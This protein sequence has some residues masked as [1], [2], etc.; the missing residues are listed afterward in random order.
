MTV[1]PSHLHHAEKAQG[2]SAEGR[3]DSWGDVHLRLLDHLAPPSVLVDAGHDILHLSPAAGRFL[4]FSGGEPSRNLLH[5]VH[6]ALRVELRAALD[7]AARHNE[8]SAV[9]RV[10]ADLGNGSMAI[11]MRVLPA[12]DIAAGLMLVIFQ[13]E[14]SD[15][16]HDGDEAAQVHVLDPVARQL[17][18]E[19]ERLKAQLR[20]T[21]EQHE[22]STEQLKASNEELQAMNEE[23]RSAAGELET[24][25]RD[26]QSISEKLTTV[27]H[28]L[29]SKVDE[30]GHANSDMHNLMDAT[31]I[32]TVFLDRQ[33]RI[34]RYTPSAVSLFHLIATDVGRPL[35]D[36]TSPLRYPTLGAD[37]K[38]ALETLTTVERE[39]GERGGHWYLARIRPYRTIDDRIAGVVLTFV[40]ITDRKR[41]QE[42]LLNADARFRAIVNQATV[43]V[44]QLDL[45]GRLTFANE[46]MCQLLGYAESELMGADVATLVHPDDLPLH[47][48]RMSRLLHQHEPFEIEK[49]LLRRDG[50]ELWVHNS[51]TCLPDAH[52]HV[53]AT[54]AVCVDI[55]ERKR[56]ES[57]LRN[58][59]EH[60]RM[61]V[62]NA[63]EYAIFTTDLD[64]RI[65]GW[66]TG[67]QRILGYTGQEAIGRS[68]DMI[69]TPEDQAEGAPSAEAG[70]ALAEGRA[71]DD[72]WHVRKD[73]SRLWAS[74]VMMAMHDASGQ[75]AGFVKILRDQTDVRR[76]Q[77]ALEQAL[78]DNEN[79]RTALEAANVAKDQ[80]LAVLSHELRTP[81]TPAVM[82]LQLLS[83]RKD[84]PED[85]HQ[86]LELIRRNIRV[87]SHL[88]DDLL[89][90][91]RISRGTLEMSHEQV[92]LHEI[93]RSAVEVCSDDLQAKPQ[94][95]TLA[96]DAPVST[97]LGDAHRLQ[98]VVW[99]L[100]K[101]ASKFTPAQGLIRIGTSVH[102]G[103]FRIEVSDNGMGIDVEAL[104]R[105]FEAFIQGGAWVAREFGGLGLGLSISKATVEAHGGTLRAASPG[106]GLGA[107][108]TLELPL[109]AT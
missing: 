12:R 26:L 32:A 29:K 99:N 69:F 87:E 66:N 78:R 92:D 106:R 79:A 17:D 81:L 80:F 14:A 86:A 103:R 30:L 35:A 11:T 76:N 57:A 77:Q 8:S 9:P 37:A 84:I 41:S 102:D 82:A 74:G 49:R 72:R 93:I 96:L 42:A 109:A 19:I 2:K 85:A 43:G 34:T 100:L 64:R 5:A 40:D 53:E 60:L 97:A 33:L 28:E 104:P 55:T 90:I 31:A 62:E 16:A 10:Q 63:R 94:K 21:V 54:I 71:G 88:I 1:D 91:T 73:G 108:F 25:R 59:E 13:A 24:S 38:S 50:S 70:Q 65:T 58:S 27:N 4:Q 83:R 68:A 51:V 89:D 45:E 39:V 36:L 98:Q 44:V 7:Q 61:V 20:D 46:R 15:L 95:L 18:R 23:L 56:A 67:A 47:Q 101:N 105:I 3:A 22:A 75:L 107:T 48:Q 52:G 6:P